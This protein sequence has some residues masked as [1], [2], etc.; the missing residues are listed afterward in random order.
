[1]KA[2]A[3]STGLG[4]EVQTLVHCS[5]M[6]FKFIWGEDCFVFLLC[7]DGFVR[8]ASSKNPWEKQLLLMY[9][10]LIYS[11]MSIQDVGIF[12]WTKTKTPQHHK[13]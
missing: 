10:C 12:L 5:G 13:N 4:Q 6:S 9:F 3:P 11:R 7:D 2:A 8:E 1:M